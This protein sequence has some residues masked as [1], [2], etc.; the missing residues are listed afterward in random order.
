MRGSTSCPRASGFRFAALAQAAAR[1]GR[2]LV[3]GFV[4]D[5]VH[6]HD[7]QAGLAP[8]LL[9]YADTRPKTVM[10][11]HNLAFQ[12]VF[13]AELLSAIGLPPQSFT[14]TGVEYHGSIGYLKAGLQ[15]ADRLTTVSHSR[16]IRTPSAGMG[17]DG[18]LRAE[19]PCCPV[20]LTASMIRSGIRLT[21]RAR[22]K[23][24]LQNRIGLEVKPE[25]LLFGVISR[26]SSQ[27]GLDLLFAVMSTFVAL[28]AQFALR[29]ALATTIW[30]MHSRPPN[31]TIRATSA[32]SSAATKLSRI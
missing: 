11:V 6:T 14:F 25:A 12:G 15:L 18:L 31:R 10:T 17:L 2:G 13:P 20:S 16:E 1:I 5:I 7:W 9:F 19:R 3:S 29:W 22:N 24:A 28:G 32:V 26:L 30:S 21:R 4:P 27:K 8:A 23:T